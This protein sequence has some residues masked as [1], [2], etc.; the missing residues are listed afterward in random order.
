MFDIAFCSDLYR[1][2]GSQ[3]YSERALACLLWA[4]IYANESYLVGTRDPVPPLYESGVYWQEE[5][6]LGRTACPQGNGQEL[7]LGIR[8]V[9]QQGHADC[10]DVCAYRV[11]ELRMGRAVPGRGLPPFPGH[12]KVTAIPPP[13]Q[14]DMT[15]A[16]PDVWPGFFSRKTGPKEITLHIVVCW[17][18]GEVEDPS[19]MLGMGGAR[20]FG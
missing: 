12:P 17:P 13:W 6:P 19:R 8:Q 18:D 5:R 20:R 7:F 4:L 2:P 16:G 10:E 14:G 1:Y 9:L 11:A 3:P 15:P